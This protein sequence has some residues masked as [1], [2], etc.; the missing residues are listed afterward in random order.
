MAKVKI[1]LNESG[2]RELLRS[3][4]MK[5]ICEG[6]ANKALG[7]LGNGHIT[8][9]VMWPERVTTTIHA[10]SYKAKKE[11]LENNTILKALK[12]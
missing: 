5:E 10:E 9:T 3:Q 1:E 2:V 8:K 6:Y 7:R 12:G 4:E 11:N